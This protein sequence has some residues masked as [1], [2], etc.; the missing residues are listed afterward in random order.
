MDDHQ[1]LSVAFLGRVGGRT[2]TL[3]EFKNIIL[4]GPF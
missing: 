1:T 3:K 4:I 2:Y